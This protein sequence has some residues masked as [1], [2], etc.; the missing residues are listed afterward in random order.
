MLRSGVQGVGHAKF[1]L[2]AGFAELVARTTICGF[3]PALV[4]GGAI[5]STSSLASYI[6]LCFGDPGAWLLAVLALVYPTF[7]YLLC[8]KKVTS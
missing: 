2:I 6:S 3:I 4:N 8:G 7:K 1:T 5:N